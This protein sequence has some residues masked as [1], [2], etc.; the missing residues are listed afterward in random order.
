MRVKEIESRNNPFF[1]HLCRL[2]T[3]KGVKKHTNALFAGYRQ[4]KEIVEH[5]PDHCEGLV[6]PRGVDLNNDNLPEDIFIYLLKD[7]LFK[8]IDQFGTRQAIL[9]A[10]FNAIREWDKKVEW[11]GGCTLF[12][13]FQDPVNVGAVVRSA[14][15][16]GVERIV[17]LKEAAHPFHYKSTRVAGS[18]LFRVEFL[19]GPSI[20]DLKQLKYPLITLSPE[21]IDIGKFSFPETFGLIPG[22]EGPGIPLELEKLEKLGIPMKTG[23]ESLNASVSTGI[24]L[25]LWRNGKGP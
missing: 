4:V 22:L 18:P 5:F 10:R 20:K 21:G 3:G 13:P 11:P 16:F 23:V 25:Y 6:L 15:A 2:T 8:E 7:D 19:S 12:I 9:L 24:A 14:A 1:K 17:L